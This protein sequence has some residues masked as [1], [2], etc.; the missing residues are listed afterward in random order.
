MNRPDCPVARTVSGNACD[1]PGTYYCDSD[2]WGSACRRY[3]DAPRPAAPAAEAGDELR[4]LAA[5]AVGEWMR[6][7]NLD[8]AAIPLQ[9]LVEQAAEAAQ[10][11]ETVTRVRS[12]RD[13]ATD[14]KV[15]AT[16]LDWALDGTHG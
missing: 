16:A 14:G 11:R 6:T 3:F 12:M 15:T 8:A 1:G 2:I 13:V 9:R 5:R 4:D 7:G 10:L